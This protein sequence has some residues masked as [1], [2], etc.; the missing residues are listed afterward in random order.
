MPYATNEALPLAV[1]QRLPARAQDIFREAFN[2]AWEEYG[3]DE[4]AA[5]RVAWSAVK[6]RYEKRGGDW[7]PRAEA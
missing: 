6:R 3:H 2:H 7:V 4:G 1:R 5:F